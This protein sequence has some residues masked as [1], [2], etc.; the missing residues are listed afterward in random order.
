VDDIGI[1]I[2]DVSIRLGDTA[3]QV[4]DRLAGGVRELVADRRS[5]AAS[6]TCG[7]RWLFP[8]SAEGRPID[9]PVLSRRL[10]RL[11]IGCNQA[12]RAAPAPPFVA[13]HKSG[14]PGRDARAYWANPQ[15]RSRRTGPDRDDRSVAKA[16]A[17]TRGGGRSKRSSARRAVCALSGDLIAA[18][19]ILVAPMSGI[20]S[21]N[22]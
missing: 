5:G 2:E 8:G 15:A 7:P 9:E 11:G 22:A 20:E 19:E 6:T 4:P 13:N 16:I 14:L 12:R 3:I 1:D 10:K 18:G 17:A 21:R